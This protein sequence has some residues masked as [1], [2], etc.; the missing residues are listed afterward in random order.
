MKRPASSTL[1]WP[2]VRSVILPFLWPRESAGLRARVVIAFALLVVAKIITVQ[3]PF[4]FKTVVDRLSEPEAAML[5]LPLAALLAYGLA[6]L[7][8]AGFAEL[9]DAIFAKVAETAGRLVSLR[10]FS[11]LFSLSLRYHLE[12]RTGELAR[13]IERGVTA[14]TFLLGIVL[15][16]VGPT[17]LEFALV[18]GILLVKYPWPFATV[19][20]VTIVVYALFTF[21]ASEWRIGIRREMNQ[22]D[23]EVRAQTVDSLLNYE[24]VK[25]FTNEGFERARLDRTLQLYQA[26]AIRSQTSL[27]AL[28]FGQ[29][30]IIAVGVTGVMI[31]AARGV[32]AGTMTVG[33]VVLV[34]TFLLQ[35]YQP[36]NFL[37]VVYRQVRQSLTDLENL[38]ALLDLEPEVKDR[39]GARPL[40]LN[41][42]EVRFDGVSF[43]YDPRR[44]VLQDV[45]FIV[46][47]GHTLALVGRSGAGKS[48]VVRLLFRFYDVD[49]GAILIDGQYLRDLTQESLR[50]AIGLVPQDT[51]LFND[52]IRA[53]IAYGR[54]GA[55]QAEIEAA[56][57]A[58][59]IHEFI[60][61]LPDGY[62]TMV[63]ERGLKLSGGEKQ[64]VAIARMVLKDP[65][66]LVF[67]EAT[68]ALDSGTERLIQG[69]LRRLS[70][71]RTTLI[72]AHRLSTVV[73]A[74]QILVLEDGRMVEHGRHHQLLA[75]GGHYAQMWARQQAAP[76]A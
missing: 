20:F 68:S 11:H 62:D 51:V 61:R 13:V 30:G 35:L 26:A 16:N 14:I 67:D 44:P 47:A 48:T 50:A 65:P 39:P 3:V 75:R 25:A 40:A 12:R 74:D 6:R 34:N 49:E 57:R 59:Q 55:A 69:A 45:D 70:T 54:P 41:A 18:I 36:L 15:F 58:A 38:M 17:L 73:D 1:D 19:V 46:P 63:G 31:M 71:G 10:V 33:D 37:G 43:G 5:A 2:R 27:A 60:G 8:A 76:A 7:C 42:A 23:N 21:L 56:A 29:A 22:R 28:N 52:T 72:I 24:T 4:L 9:R 32:V 53:N 66:I 64:R